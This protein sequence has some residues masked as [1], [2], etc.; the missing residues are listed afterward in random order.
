MRLFLSPFRFLSV[1]GKPNIEF[2]F[3]Q[4]II[5][6]STVLGVY[7]ASFAGFRIA[8]DFD[9]YQSLS[10]VSYLEKSLEAEFVDNIE[11]VEQWIAEYPEAP[12]KWHARELTPEATHRLDDMV[13]ST[14]R[15]S[16]RT[17]EVHPEIITGVRRFYTGIEAQMTSLFQQQ[18]ANGYSRRA[19]E[20]MKQQVAAARTD[21][22]PK[23]R[24]EIETLDA[25]LA[26]MMD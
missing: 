1:S 5:L 14:M 25:E 20:N 26:D 16:P 15:Y 10:D 13:W 24:G 22:L 21:I 2:W 19:I 11:R 12:M 7:L 9:R 17:F 18:S 4:C 3:T 23:L 6:A 8:V